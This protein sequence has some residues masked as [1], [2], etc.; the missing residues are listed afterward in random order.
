MNPMKKN[1]LY[2]IFFMSLI[3]C[4][5]EAI[6]KLEGHSGQALRNGTVG[7]RYPTAPGRQYFLS[8]Q[9]DS[10]DCF[11]LTGEI[12]PGKVA[13]LNFGYQHLPLYVEKQHYRVVKESDNYYILS[14]QKESLQNRYV[15]YMCQ[16]YTLDSAYNRLCQGYDTISDINRKALLSDR[17]KLDFARRND[18]I[19]QGI[20][21][22]A[23]T[24]IALNIVNELMYFCEVDY[25]FFYEGDGSI[26]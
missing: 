5:Q 12:T 17:L 24:E 23:G 4:K 15:Q 26:G 9:A 13:F 14:D 8:T 25:R 7:L 22:F 18:R 16:I 10:S 19:I 6:F 3:A 1:I 20:K 21:E 11:F 2:I